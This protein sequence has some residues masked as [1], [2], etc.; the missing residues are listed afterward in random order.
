MA[1]LRQ[2]FPRGTDLLGAFASLSE[3]SWLV[4][5]TND[6]ERPCNLK[7]QQRR[8]KRLCCVD[9]LSRQSNSEKLIASI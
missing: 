4:S 5:S 6:H 9:R 2:Y 3:Q 8:F 1:L 7:P